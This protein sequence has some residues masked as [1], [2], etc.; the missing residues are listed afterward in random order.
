MTENETVV[1]PLPAPQLAASHALALA[2]N[3]EWANL[4]LAE[5]AGLSPEGIASLLEERYPLPPE[6]RWMR[7][8]TAPTLDEDGNVT[9]VTGSGRL[10]WA[11]APSG[12]VKFY[13]YRP[14]PGE[15]GKS[16]H[17]LFAYLPTQGWAELGFP[18]AQYW[19]HARNF[20][21]ARQLALDDPR[22]DIRALPRHLD[23]LERAVRALTGVNPNATGVLAW[24]DTLRPAAERA[25]LSE[26]RSRAW[27][28]GLSS[29]AA[30]DAAM[31]VLQE[32]RRRLYAD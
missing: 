32:L 4:P 19:C 11:V 27:E 8:I 2:Y 13:V 29:L 1:A 14:V 30:V 18:D 21:D 7:G 31:E 28:M 6:D 15:R 26:A 9:H 25:E 5:L 22:R 3:H 20:E 23:A 24:I 17:V 10:E 12:G 16:V